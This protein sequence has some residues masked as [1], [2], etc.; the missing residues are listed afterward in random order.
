MPAMEEEEWVNET[1]LVPT[2]VWEEEPVERLEHRAV[3][4]E[5][6]VPQVT[7]LAAPVS[8]CS[9]GDSSYIPTAT[10]SPTY[11]H[12]CNPQSGS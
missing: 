10:K 4:E 12:G 1:R 11:A 5:R 7:S 3:T 2:E 6:S 8:S 9:S